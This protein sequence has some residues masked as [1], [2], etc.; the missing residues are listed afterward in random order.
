MDIKTIHCFLVHPAKKEEVQP[1]IGGTEVRKSGK[2][3]SMLDGIFQKS[4]TDCRI[5]IAFNHNSEGEQQNDC[6]DL[7][8]SYVKR[9]SLNNGR[10]IATRLQKVTTQT[11]GLG[12]L[13]LMFGDD[14]TRWRF[15]ISRFPADQGILVEERKDSLTVEF[16]EKV[17]MKSATAY[18][19]ALYAAK[20]GS[21][22]FWRGKAIDKQINYPGDHLAR[23]W[24]S[25]FLASSL[26][27]TSAAGTKR[28]AQGLRTAIRESGDVQ[29]KTE[30]TSAVSLAH[31]VAGKT[32]SITDFCAR[33]GLSTEV[34][35]AVRR[36]INHENLMRESFQFDLDEFKKH[37][38][39]R[40][41]ELD[42]GAILTAEVSKFE[43]VF[44][45]ERIPGPDDEVRY[46]TQ[47]HVVDERLRK[48]RN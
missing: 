17:F 22:D 36:A 46:S 41:L 23:Y 43:T 39:F 16:L 40:S 21:F 4:D 7:L 42:N 9:R 19:A 27:T 34:T 35:A 38:A 12:L 48:T 37:I 6:R 28:L 24:I 29:L 33:F 20:T 8:I 1:E 26:S 30:I 47:G 3:L 45:K 5:D 25:D 14:K 10:K 44:R 18:K 2:L 11:S 15:V 31:S 32:L 13:F